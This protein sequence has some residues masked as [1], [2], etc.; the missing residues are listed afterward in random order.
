MNCETQ[1][2]CAHS[3]HM[4]SCVKFNKF[5]DKKSLFYI[6]SAVEVFKYSFKYRP[7]LFKVVN[8][9]KYVEYDKLY[10]FELIDFRVENVTYK[11]KYGVSSSF[12][13]NSERIFFQTV[14]CHSRKQIIGKELQ[15]GG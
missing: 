14:L 13:G 8:V 1:L 3:T 7:F 15:S 2:F 12:G 4:V 6:V 10:F 5:P 11:L 9:V